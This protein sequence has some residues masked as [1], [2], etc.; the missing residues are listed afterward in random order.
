MAELVAVN[1]LLLKIL[2]C[3]NFSNEQGYIT[4]NA[5]VSRQPVVNINV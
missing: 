2:W 5:F 4:G 1:V 3:K